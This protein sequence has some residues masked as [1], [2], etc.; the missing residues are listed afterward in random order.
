MS[1]EEIVRNI[2]KGLKPNIARYIGI[3]GNKNLNELKENV[4]K[5]EMIEF[6]VTGHIPQTPSEFKTDIIKNQ[7]NQINSQTIEDNKISDEIKELKQIIQKSLNMSEK[8][9]SNNFSHA[10]KKCD[11]CGLN[12]H[13]TNNC[14]KKPNHNY[15]TISKM[16]VNTFIH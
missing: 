8:Q 2:M 7:L 16:S 9:N 6:M 10:N 14:F 5:Y 13:N 15:T 11:I 12:N 4:R 3:I 1:Q